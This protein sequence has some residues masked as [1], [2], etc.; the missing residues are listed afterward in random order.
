[1]GQLLSVPLVL[2]G[3]WLIRRALAKPA[4]TTS[5]EV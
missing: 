2:V 4:L 3:A 5:I 1:M